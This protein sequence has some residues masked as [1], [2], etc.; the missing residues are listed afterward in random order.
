MRLDAKACKGNNAGYVNIIVPGRRL[1]LRLL[2]ALMWAVYRIITVI[3]S[4]NTVDISPYL[5]VILFTLLSVLAPGPGYAQTTAPRS[6]TRDSP[7]AG[8][9]QPASRRCHRRVVRNQRVLRCAGSRSDQVRD[10]S[11]CG[12]R[13]PSDYRGGSR[14]WFLATIV[15]SGSVCLRRGRPGWSGA[16][17]A[18][19]QRSAQADQQDYGLPSTD[20]S[21]RSV[22]E[23]SRSGQSRRKALW[24]RRSSPND[25]AGVGASSKK[26][27]EVRLSSQ[28]NKDL[29]ER[30]EQLRHDALSLRAGQTAP[31]GLALFLRQGMTAWMRASLPYAPASDAGTWTPPA[32]LHG[33]SLDI[34]C[35]ITNILAGMILSQQQE[36]I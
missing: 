3:C 26:T 2:C 10:A 27:A 22:T 7:P 33:F 20:S 32:T 8:N 29:V 15:L 34:Q 16:S 13:R 1:G 11:P 25:R 19:T 31:A 23:F 9:T 18:W 5:G 24:C 4:I 14:I 17:Q 30:Y 28:H 35:E 6:Q 12:E 21:G 36:A